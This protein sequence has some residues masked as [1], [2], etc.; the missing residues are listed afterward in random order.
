[1][2]AIGLSPSLAESIGIDVFRYRLLAFVVGSCTC[3]LMGTFFAHYYRSLAPATFDPFKSLYVH[4]YALLGGIDSALLGPIVGSGILILV[5]EALR[6]AKEVEPV[7][8]GIL[9]ILLDIFL[10]EEIIDAIVR[11]LEVERGAKK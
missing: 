11:M 3:G 6:I 7:I 2:R 9:L 1:W 5:P 8:T 10:L 4:L